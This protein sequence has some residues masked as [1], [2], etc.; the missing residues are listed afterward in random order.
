V[1]SGPIAWKRPA[2]H[3]APMT[4]EPVPVWRSAACP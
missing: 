2:A 1:P 4:S 3:N